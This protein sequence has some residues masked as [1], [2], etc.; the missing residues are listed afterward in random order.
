MKYFKSIDDNKV[1]EIKGVLT[2][3]TQTEWTHIKGSIDMYF[4]FKAAKIKID[5]LDILETLLRRK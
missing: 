5:D 1:N 3:L 2:G 4:S